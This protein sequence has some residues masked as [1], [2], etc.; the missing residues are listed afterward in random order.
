M[1]ETAELVTSDEAIEASDSELLHQPEP[2]ERARRPRPDKRGK[3]EPAENKPKLSPVLT[4]VRNSEDVTLSDVLDGLGP[5]GSFRIH[6][7]RTAPEEVRGPDGKMIKCD[8][9]LRT[10]SRKIDQE[11]IRAHHGGGTYQLKI[12]RRNDHGKLVFHTARTIEV[13]GDPIVED[14]RS[15]AAAS[16]PAAAPV[17]I[18]T[19]VENPSLAAKAFDILSRQVETLQSEPR[20]T[21]DNSAM[22][23]M[24]GMLREELAAARV[25]SAELRRQVLTKTPEDP[26]KDRLLERLLTDDTARLTA[27]RTQYESELRIAR[28]NAIAEERRIRDIAERE[29]SDVRQSYERE[30]TALRQSHDL[31]LQMMR[32]SHEVQ[33]KSLE[34]DVRRLERDNDELRGEIRDLRQKKDKSLIEQAREIKEVREALGDAD[35]EGSKTVTDK[36]VDLMT[37]PA[38]VEF[39]QGIVGRMA[40]GQAQPQTPQQ[41]QARPVTPPQQARPRIVAAPDGTRFLQSPD[42]GLRPLKPRVRKPVPAPDVAPAGPAME[43]PPVPATAPLPKLDPEIVAQS[44]AYLERAFAGNQDPDVV[45][46]SVRP[47]LPDDVLAALRDLGVD[48]FMSRIARLPVSS[49]LNTQGGKNWVRKVGAALVG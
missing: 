40:G 16:T 24:V 10:Y 19:P 18:S 12:A 47:L 44:V 35:D 25:E 32:S 31:A 13:A 37:N 8:G 1:S 3:A 15:F 17:A 30:I 46:Q 2:V 33:I 49:Q 26:T 43:T 9:H 20:K 38:A 36:I 48:Q 23:S 6:L 28:D 22:E 45:A 7:A 4:A 34:S 42:G 5:D 14:L 11:F 21:P 41:V 29:K 27:V 39:A